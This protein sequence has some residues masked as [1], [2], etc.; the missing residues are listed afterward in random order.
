LQ[1]ALLLPKEK[2]DKYFWQYWPEKFKEWYNF[3]EVN[4]VDPA[5]ICLGHALS[6]N[7]VDKVVI[8]IDSPSQLSNLIN[9]SRKNDHMVI[10]NFSCSDLRL[11]DPST[12]ELTN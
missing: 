10:P 7:W 1:G 4:E 9:I 2:L 8:G 11:I 12:W 6:Q 3:L 5:E